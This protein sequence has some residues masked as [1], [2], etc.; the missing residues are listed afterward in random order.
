MAPVDEPL[1]A[2][3]AAS[4]PEHAPF[5]PSLTTDFAELIPWEQ[6]FGQ[7]IPAT[8]LAASADEH[9]LTTEQLTIFGDSPTAQ[10]WPTL[11]GAPPTQEP[12]ATPRDSG[13]LTSPA[14][15]SGSLLEQL[16]TGM[17]SAATAPLRGSTGALPTIG[18]P[19]LAGGTSPSTPSSG[20]LGSQPP[21]VPAADPGA[22]AQPAAPTAANADAVEIAAEIL[23]V[24]RELEAAPGR[25]DLHRKLGF[26]L[27]KQGR[28]A[29]A[30]A[31]FRLAIE[32][33]RTNL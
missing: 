6:P 5:L 4:E 27:A 13:S 11:I 18:A 19:Q 24:Q 33:S 2:A 30:A 12:I 3:G 21:A 32:A 22:G 29:E 9:K 16:G 7:P 17:F 23:L 20:T 28:T 15:I 14:G 26:L 25:A 1:V 8:P 10:D 31:E